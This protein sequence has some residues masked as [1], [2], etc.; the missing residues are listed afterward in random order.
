MKLGDLFEK[1][2]SI[3]ENIKNLQNENIELKKDQLIITEKYQNV[4]KR[5]HYVE[6]LE[7]IRN[8]ITVISLDKHTISISYLLR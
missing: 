3:E 6:G 4:A 5:F 2:N 8:C 7:H 1:I